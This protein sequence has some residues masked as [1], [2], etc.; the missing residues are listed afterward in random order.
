MSPLKVDDYYRILILSIKNTLYFIVPLTVLMFFI[1]IGFELNEGGSITLFFTP[2]FIIN[3]IFH[4]LMLSLYF[5]VF[6]L[7]F[8]FHL[9][10]LKTRK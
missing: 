8:A 3:F 1:E 10:L 4:E 9:I 6:L 5:V 2:E 7:N